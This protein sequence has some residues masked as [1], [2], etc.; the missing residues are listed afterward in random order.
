[1]SRYEFT[2]EGH[3][4]VVG[5]DG[6]LETYFVQVWKGKPESAANVHRGFPE[7]GPHPAL[8]LGYER[9]QVQTVEELARHLKPHA[10]L[11]PHIEQ[12]LRQDLARA[13]APTELQGHFA[14]LFARSTG[15]APAPTPDQNADAA[16]TPKPRHRHRH[17]L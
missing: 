10:S 16:E 13:S 1:M 3:T 14:D 12:S 6:P 2:T 8:W 17:R 5:W 4:V 15:P 9:R 11:P 7:L